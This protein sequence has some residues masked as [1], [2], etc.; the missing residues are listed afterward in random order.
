MLASSVYVMPLL[1]HPVHDIVNF[2]LAIRF[3]YRPMIAPKYV[4]PDPPGSGQDV[5]LA[6]CVKSFT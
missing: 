5:L 1:S 6:P 3:A 4:S 2:A